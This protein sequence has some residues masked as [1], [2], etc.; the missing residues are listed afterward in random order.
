VRDGRAVADVPVGR[1]PHAA[2]AAAGGRAF[3]ADER[4][5]AL[6]VVHGGRVERAL[7][8]P[9]QPGGIA[10]TADGR[11]VAV[12][13]VRER[14][15]TVYDA[16]TL[17]RIGSI[18]AG[19]GPTHVAI[20]GSEA[21]VADTQGG[22]LLVFS[23]RPRLEFVRRANLRGGPYGM[24]L[25][26]DRVWVTLTARD[27]VVEVTADGHPRV[28]RRLPTVRQPNSVAAR[29]GEIA[30][31]GRDAGVLQLIDPSGG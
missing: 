11:L 30:V 2:V 24:A 17:R 13:S 7:P 5:D 31:T 23:L 28:L 6:T 15:L 27:E 12:V 29:P 3:V 14:M 9:L 20:R 25:V 18:P 26:G 21:F 22:A 8:T 1:G 19:I 4:G 16:L 10:A